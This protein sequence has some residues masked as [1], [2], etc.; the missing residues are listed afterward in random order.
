MKLTI[1]SVGPNDFGTYK[2]VARN[3]IGETDGTIKI[4]SK[5]EDV[6]IDII[7]IIE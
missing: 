2:C 3:S 7:W 4:Y 6:V 1:K 5:F